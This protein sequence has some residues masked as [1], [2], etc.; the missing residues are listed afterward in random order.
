MHPQI[1]GLRVIVDRPRIRQTLRLSLV[2]PGKPQPNT[3]LVPR[4]CS[5]LTLSL[6]L[7]HQPGKQHQNTTPPHPWLVVVVAVKPPERTRRIK[8]SIVQAKGTGHLMVLGTHRMEN[9]HARKKLTGKHTPMVPGGP[10]VTRP[11]TKGKLDTNQCYS[12]SPSQLSPPPETKPRKIDCLR[13]TAINSIGLPS[14]C[15]V[16]KYRL[17]RGH[18]NPRRGNTTSVTIAPSSE[19]VAH[20]SQ[21]ESPDSQ[22]QKQ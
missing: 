19:V 18:H 17:A 9:S 20:R 21:R 14:P 22:L 13:K 15:H 8:R 6:T 1:A 4:P 7:L 5:R 3:V 11:P 12:P 16:R 10:S 2:L